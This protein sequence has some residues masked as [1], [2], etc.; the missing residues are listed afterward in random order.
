MLLD[1]EVIAKWPK[2]LYFKIFLEAVDLRTCLT[3]F[4]EKKAISE[5]LLIREKQ[6]HKEPSLVVQYFE[7][8]SAFRYV[9]NFFMDSNA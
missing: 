2:P 5:L 1:G 4:P 8:K 9:L 3:T 7:L 6:P